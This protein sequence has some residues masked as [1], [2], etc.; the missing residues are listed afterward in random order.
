M[1]AIPPLLTLATDSR[2]T[3]GPACGSGTSTRTYT[4]DSQQK[5]TQIVQGSS[6][7]IYSL[8]D[9]AGRPTLGMRTGGSQ[10]SYTYD[11]AARIMTVRT[12][13]AGIS[14]VAAITFDARGIEIQ[15]VDAGSV[16]TTTTW[17]IGSTGTACK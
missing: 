1:K 7:T 16:T 15:E 6:T 10:L 13:S 11:D 5:L 9:G 3:T 8:W 4:Y 2:T 12:T 17:T 14:S